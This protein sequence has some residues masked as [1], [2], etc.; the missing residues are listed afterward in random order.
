MILN[1][2]VNFEIKQRGITFSVDYY[3][4]LLG[5][6]SILCEDQDAIDDA[7]GV[8][9]NQAYVDE[10]KDFFKHSNYKGLTHDLAMLSNEYYFNYDAPV[11]L[12]LKLSN[13]SP[14]T[15]KDKEELFAG[16]KRVPDEVLEKFIE[17]MIAFEK[18]S[19]YKHFYK[20][21]FPLYETVVNHYIADFEYYHA[22]DFLLSFLEIETD[23]DYHINLMLGITNANYGVTVENR[24]YSNNRPYHKTRYQDIPDF[25]YDALYST[26]LIVHEFAHS[27]INRL[28]ADYRDQIHGIDKAGYEG[29]LDELGYGDS[30][31]TLIIEH[32]IRAI[33]CLYVKKYFKEQYERYV[34]FNVEDGYLKLNEVIRCISVSV[35]VKQVVD[36]FQ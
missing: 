14:I 36:L 4:E 2:T 21:H 18:S 24:V 10:V 28:V 6:L 3:V 33:E 19:D 7:G 12:M 31:E 30:L 13:K 8:R 15:D 22:H 5:V 27:F 29:L 34:E 26:T 9:C 20:A 23:F 35:D 32:I 1:E 11:W 17:D 25:S 16:R